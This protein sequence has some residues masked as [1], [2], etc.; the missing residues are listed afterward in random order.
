MLYSEPRITE[1]VDA[2]NQPHIRDEYDLTLEDVKIIEAFILLRG[3]TLV[4]TRR[5][6]ICWDPKDNMFREAAVDGEA[7]ILVSGDKDL[8]DIETFEG[9]SIATPAE[10]LANLD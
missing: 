2:L 1:L 5:I 6:T 3:E 7:D 10:L 4:P 8:L 9:I